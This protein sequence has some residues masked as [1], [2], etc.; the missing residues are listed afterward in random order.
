MESDSPNGLLTPR[1]SG[2]ETISCI[3]H[4]RSV[5]DNHLCA[6]HGDCAELVSDLEQC[7]STLLSSACLSVCVMNSQW[8]MDDQRMQ[9]WDGILSEP[10]ILIC[11]LHFVC[12]SAWTLYGSSQQRLLRSCR[13]HFFH[14]SSDKEKG[15]II[16]IVD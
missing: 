2:L 1:I 6:S 15:L 16:F 5:C 7:R 14:F 10:P 4:R 13:F 3:I 9:E 8:V 12:T 11:F